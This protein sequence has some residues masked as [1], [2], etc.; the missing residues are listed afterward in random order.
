MYVS[1]VFPYKLSTTLIVRVY[2]YYIILYII[3]DKHCHLIIFSGVWYLC[4][5]KVKN[6]SQ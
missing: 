4:K 5:A 3:N 6:C 2:K 1:D